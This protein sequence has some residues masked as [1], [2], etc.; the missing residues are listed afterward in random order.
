MKNTTLINRLCTIAALSLALGG[1]SGC[2]LVR[3][4][5]EPAPRPGPQVPIESS[6]D[7]GRVDVVSR[8][9]SL[10]PGY[11]NWN[12]FSDDKALRRG[13]VLFVQINQKNEGKKDATTA[14]SRDSKITASINRLFGIQGDILD[15]T[16]GVPE[17]INVEASNQFKG[18]GNTE[19]KDA[20]IATVSV[21]VTD[22][23]GNGNLVIYGHQIVQVNNEA[24]VLTVQ[25]IVRPSDISTD[26]TIESNRIA[27]ARIEFS[28]SGVITDKQHPGLGMKVFDW[29]WPF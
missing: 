21:T 7:P 24:S 10:W 17:Q 28:G 22:V 18:D 3:L 29:V 13:D 26:N 16:T 25:G 12:I 19:R 20:L 6:A 8:D 11:S 23:L 4:A 1:S 2:A 27:N 5:Y 14:T 9:G 15:H